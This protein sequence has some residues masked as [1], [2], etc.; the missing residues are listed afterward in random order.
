MTL[1]PITVA[2]RGCV[3]ALNLLT[4]DGSVSRLHGCCSLS[5]FDEWTF[6]ILMGCVVSAGGGILF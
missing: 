5:G 1:N 2:W 3:M 4:G 6:F